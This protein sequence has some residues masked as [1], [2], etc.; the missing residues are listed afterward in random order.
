V[1]FA[2]IVLPGIDVSIIDEEPR[3]RL[4][5]SIYDTI[6]DVKKTTTNHASYTE[7]NLNAHIVVKH[8]QI[9]NMFATSNE[10]K[11]MFTPVRYLDREKV[12]L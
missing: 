5:I 1:L 7:E 11:V 8:M 6:I 3:E 9:D 10:F 12:D 4:L 2:K